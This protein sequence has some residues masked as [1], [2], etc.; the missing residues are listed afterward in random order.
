MLSVTFETRGTY[1]DA[2]THMNFQ[3]RLGQISRATVNHFLSR[4]ILLG[5]D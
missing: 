4:R 2:K 1:N 5:E 3:A